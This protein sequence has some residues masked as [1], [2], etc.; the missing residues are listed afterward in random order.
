MKLHRPIDEALCISVMDKDA[1]V[2]RM[3]GESI[4]VPRPEFMGSCYI[5]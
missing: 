1:A 3:C 5:H 4:Y 2:M